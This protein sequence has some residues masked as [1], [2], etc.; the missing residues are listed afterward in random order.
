MSP[1]ELPPADGYADWLQQRC[2]HHLGVV[3]Q[4]VEDF[5]GLVGASGPE[6][7]EGWNDVQVALGNVF[8]AASLL[9]NVHP[10]D[11]VRTQAEAAEQDA[12]RLLTDLSLDRGIY[13]VLASVDA[14]PLDAE[15]R[16]MLEKSL[17]DFRRAGV[18]RDESTRDRLRKLAERQT[19]VGQTFSKNIREGVGRL[20][21]TPERLAGLPDDFVA[22]HAVGEDGLVQLTTEYPDYV[23]VMTFATD[24]RCARR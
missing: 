7:L 18:D 23:P 8:S 24:R 1:L 13:D 9:A 10:D 5:R 11:A 20:R 16:R 6:V 22:A 21:V 2:D 14:E 15:A 17:L 12:H 19:E 4:L 3:R